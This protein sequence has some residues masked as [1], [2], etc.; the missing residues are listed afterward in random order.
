M[1]HGIAA[2][3][4]ARNDNRAAKALRLNPADFAVAIQ[5]FGKVGS[6]GA[7][8]LWEEEIRVVATSDLL[9]GAYNPK[10]LDIGKLCRYVERCTYRSSAVVSV[11]SYKRRR[12]AIG[13]RPWD[14][15]YR[16]LQNV[17]LA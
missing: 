17:L 6:A 14:F 8:L 11:I 12:T 16:F 9:G 10:G 15:M 1:F 13:I 3:L 2:V 5:G 4:L 7:R